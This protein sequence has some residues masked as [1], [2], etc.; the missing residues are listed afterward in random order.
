MG[1]GGLRRSID[2]LL[3]LAGSSSGPM[4]FGSVR[5]R[6]RMVDHFGDNSS[7]RLGVWPVCSPI[8]EM[9]EENDQIIFKSAS[10]PLLSKYQMQIDRAALNQPTRISQETSQ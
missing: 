2:L 6:V 3:P 1:C 7:R 4:A 9:T 5:L 10:D 8:S